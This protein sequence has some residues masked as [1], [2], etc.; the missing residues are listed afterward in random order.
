MEMRPEVSHHRALKVQDV[1]NRQLD[2]C[3]S[4]RTMSYQIILP[5]KYVFAAPSAYTTVYSVKKT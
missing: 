3:D 2:M 1:T 4:G 5:G